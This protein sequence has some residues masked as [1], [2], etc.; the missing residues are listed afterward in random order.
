VRD[1]LRNAKAINLPADHHVIHV[2]R[3]HFLV[4]GQEGIVDPVGMLGAHLEVDVHVIHGMTN[5]LQNSIRAVKSLQLEVEDIVFTGVAASLAVLDT[6]DKELGALV[7]DLGAG[8]SNYVVYANG[9]I[10]HSGVLTVGGDHVTNDLAYGLKVS[11][12]RAEELKLAY[13]AA[14]VEDADKGRTVSLGATNGLPGTSVNLEHL[15]RIM[16][17]RLEETFEI[18]AEEIE[19][20]GLLDYLRAGVFLCGGGAR[21]PGVEKLAARVFGLPVVVGRAKSIGGLASA[22]DQPEFAAAIGLAKVGSFQT[23]RRKTKASLGSRLRATFNHIFQK[24]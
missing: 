15:R 18:I 16:S 24:V 9:L 2:V 13:G 4:Q 12:N 19:P 5:R 17:L 3:Q 11:M 20:T 7:I 14:L 21:V 22:L 6:P 1:V 10:E 23:D 8:V